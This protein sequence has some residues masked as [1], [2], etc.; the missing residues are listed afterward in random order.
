MECY[1]A[2][3]T[4]S[5]DAAEYLTDEESIA[6]FL[7]ASAEMGDPAVLL[8]ALGTVAR[9]RSMTKLADDSGLGRESLYKA[10]KPGAQPRYDTVMKVLGALGVTMVFEAAKASNAPNA[11]VRQKSKKQAAV[12]S[13][14][15]LPARRPAT[16]SRAAAKDE[17]RRMRKAKAAT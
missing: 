15:S 10:L 2:I 6:D 3:K 13:K 5:F 4:L 8:N 1:M 11:V 14:K 7:N 9:A 12:T 16:E 17:S